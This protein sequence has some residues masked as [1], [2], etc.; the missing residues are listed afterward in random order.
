M[1]IA[2]LKVREPMTTILDSEE[3]PMLLPALLMSMACD[4]CKAFNLLALKHNIWV[5]H[6]S[7]LKA[8]AEVMGEFIEHEGSTY[9]VKQEKRLQMQFA[10]GQRAHGHDW[11]E[12]AK[13]AK[14]NF[15]LPGSVGLADGM[16]AQ[17]SAEKHKT[18]TVDDAVRRYSEKQREKGEPGASLLEESEDAHRVL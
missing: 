5:I 14:K 16:N 10:M 4:P 9:A 2:L 17:E 15:D 3:G 12:E 7:G 18:I 13:L 6:D 8:A 11:E 1:P